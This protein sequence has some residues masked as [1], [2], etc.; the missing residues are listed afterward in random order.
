MAWGETEE[1]PSGAPFK[2]LLRWAEPLFAPMRERALRQWAEAARRAPHRFDIGS[3]ERSLHAAFAGPALSMSVRALLLELAIARHQ[4]RLQ[5]ATPERRLLEFID[6]I[7]SAAGR[8]VID[9]RYPLLRGDIVRQAT[10]TEGFLAQCLQRIEADYSNL[11]SLL[12]QSSQSARLAGFDMGQGDRH[13]HGGSVVKLD[14]EGAR[15]LYKPRSLAMDVAFARFIDAL[16]ERGVEPLQRATVTLDC[17]AYG[18]AGWVEHAAVADEAAAAR[19]YRR[20]GGLVAIAYALN[21]TDLHLENLIACGEYPVLIDLETVL[22]PWIKRHEE[23]DPLGVP[24]APSILVSGLLPG[25][26]SVDAWDVSGLAWAEHRY[27]TRLAAGAGT[28]ELRLA[29][30]DAVIR[31]EA[32]V[33]RLV[34]G[35]PIPSTGH[36]AGIVEGFES[37]Y[38]GLLRLKPALCTEHGLLAPFAPL[39]TRT[40]LR[41]TQIY[42]RLLDAMSHPQYLRSA[43][44]REALLD[45]LELGGREWAFLRRSQKYEREAMQRGDVPRFLARVDGADIHDV[46]GH[47][48]EGLCQLS[49]MAE[50]QRRVRRMS[51]RDLRRQRYALV[52][53]LECDRLAAAKHSAGEAAPP[54]SM[55]AS[56][57]RP[58][59]GASFIDT[60]AALGDDLLR[61]SFHDRHGLLLFQPEYREDENSSM[62]AM[63]SALYEGLPGIALLFAEL[64]RHEGMGR[65]ALAAEAALASCRRMLRDDPKALSSIGAFDGLSGWMYVLLLLGLRWRREALIDEA[66]GWL[67]TLAARIGE[68]HEFDLIGGSAG[69]LLV[70][71][72][73]Q[74]HRPSDD[75]LAAAT[76]CAERLAATAQRHVDGACWVGVAATEHGGLSGFAHGTAGIGAALA[77]YAQLVQ[78]AAC[79]ELAREA[80]RH[81]RAAFAARSRRWYD[82]AEELGDGDDEDPCSWCHGAP[83]VG[84]AHLLWPEATRDA[85]WHDEL[86]HCLTTTREQG[87]TEGHSLCHGQMGNLDLLLQHAVQTQD[88]DALAKARRLGQGVLEQARAG[89]RC[90]GASIA[91]EPLGLMVGIAGIAYGCLRLA[92]PI[93]TPSVMSL[94]AGPLP[95]RA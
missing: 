49:G 53:A 75:V 77:S 76:A 10:Q 44:E 72:Q 91:Q 2:P 48:V 56:A 11:V 62:A 16:A 51:M 58:Y 14:F 61:L 19:Y 85:R 43:M 79:L 95:H 82:R 12:P 70:L 40:V 63:G 26:L 30:A 9:A 41:S 80:L 84:L 81:A 6:W 83:G 60:A 92:D 42:A 15:L 55:L 93:G 27:R 64:G 47:V 65:F 39:E 78:D 66:L 69:C 94:S 29:P 8:A 31:P 35:R 1:R 33:P 4:Q 24:Y 67:P 36:A 87:M 74:R 59:R 88:A 18:Y 50:A 37:T 20:Y 3:L 13:D 34:D 23:D 25:Q 54:D 68:D 5:E 71:L 7:D 45:K 46:D 86:R 38:R 28:D 89:W 73:L 22:Q 52:Q 57:F 32:N 17:G 21:C 90:G